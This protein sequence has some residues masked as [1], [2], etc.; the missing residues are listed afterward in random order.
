MCTGPKA[1]DQGWAKSLTPSC[2][3]S[4]STAAP[5]GLT[6]FRFVKNTPPKALDFHSKREKY[7]DAPPQPNECQYRSISCWESESKA[8]DILKLPIRRGQGIARLTLH[9]A[10]GAIERRADGHISW[11]AC[12]GFD[13]IAATIE[14]VA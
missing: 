1:C 8:R 14:V 9:R 2:P 10:S 7:P 13:P 6:V 4:H 3:P 12:K 11:W 5:D